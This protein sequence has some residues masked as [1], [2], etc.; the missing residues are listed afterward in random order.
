MNALIADIDRQRTEDLSGGA[1]GN[2]SSVIRV[3][4][5]ENKAGGGD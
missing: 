3:F 4:V 1:S 5:L 2:L